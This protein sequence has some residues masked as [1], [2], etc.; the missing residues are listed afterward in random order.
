[1]NNLY[2]SIYEETCKL[3]K[4][5]ALLDKIS[6]SCEQIYSVKYTIAQHHL[7]C[8]RYRFLQATLKAD[9]FFK[10]QFIKSV[11]PWNEQWFF[12]ICEWEIFWM[13]L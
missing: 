1:M 13:C 6:V 12:F 5:K 8:M 3:S 2:I 7:R 10:K 11:Y 4:S 9:F